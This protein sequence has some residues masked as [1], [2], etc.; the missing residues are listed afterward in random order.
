MTSR[1]SRIFRTVCWLFALLQLGFPLASAVADAH[2]LGV[3]AIA[4]VHLEAELCVPSHPADCAH[5]TTSRLAAPAGE[6]FRPSFRARVIEPPA[7]AGAT[8]PR[9]SWVAPSPLPRGPP[10]LS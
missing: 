8:R 5:C 2:A 4:E 3:R 7:V 6:A 1:S 9:I 10:S